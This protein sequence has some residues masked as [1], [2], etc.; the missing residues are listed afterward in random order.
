MLIDRAMNHYQARNLFGN[1]HRLNNRRNGLGFDR[2]T[3][4]DRGVGVTI[5]RR[6]S[7]ALLESLKVKEVEGDPLLDPDALKSLIRLLRLAQVITKILTTEFSFTCY[8]LFD[9]FD[10]LLSAPWERPSAETLLQLK[11]S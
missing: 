11:C 9:H 1:S 6:T 3:V 2:Q 5:G 7:S 4:I 8:K 10:V